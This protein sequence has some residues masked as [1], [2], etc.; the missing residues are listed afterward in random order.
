MLILF[1][2]LLYDEHVFEMTSALVCVGV[3][4]S[5]GILKIVPFSLKD[6]LG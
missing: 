2:P 1:L 4:L 6:I 5:V 3:T